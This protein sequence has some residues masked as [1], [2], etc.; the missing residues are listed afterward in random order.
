MTRRSRGPTC[1]PNTWTRCTTSP[2]SSNVAFA[3]GFSIISAVLTNMLGLCT[4]T[5]RSRL[6][7]IRSSGNRSQARGFFVLVVMLQIAPVT[8]STIVHYTEIGSISHVILNALPRFHYGVCPTTFDE[9][10]PVHFRSAVPILKMPMIIR[11][12]VTR[13]HFGPL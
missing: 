4:A 2:R 13:V 7:S 1:S 5:N 3:D 9:L 8:V 12:V 10:F 11:T 6:N